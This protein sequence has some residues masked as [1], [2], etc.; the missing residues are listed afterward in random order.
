MV[1]IPANAEHDIELISGEP[2]ANDTYDAGVV[3][4]VDAPD[5]KWDWV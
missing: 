1:L 5:S 2:F 4:L 3:E